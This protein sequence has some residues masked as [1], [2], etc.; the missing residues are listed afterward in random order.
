MGSIRWDKMAEGL[1]CAGFFVESM[2]DLETTLAAAQATPGPALICVRTDRTANMS[3]PMSV[4]KRFGEVY[5][6]PSN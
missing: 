1:G 3:V 2:S 4:G 5:Q 6:G